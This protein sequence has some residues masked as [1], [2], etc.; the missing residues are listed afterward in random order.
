[1]KVTRVEILSQVELESG[2]LYIDEALPDTVRVFLNNVQTPVFGI[3]IN[4]ESNTTVIGFGYGGIEGWVLGDA[5]TLRD[6]GVEI[7]SEIDYKN[8]YIFDDQ[9]NKVYV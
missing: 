7:L 5:I 3:T 9:G 1:M 8:G 6:N 2:F 4:N